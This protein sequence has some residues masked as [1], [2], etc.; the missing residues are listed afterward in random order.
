M[1]KYNYSEL[2]H[3]INSVLLHQGQELDGIRFG[4]KASIDERISESEALLKS[5]GYA[6]PDR[7]QATASRKPV[8]VV[9]SWE[10]LCREAELAVGT[11]TALE[12]IFTPEELAENTKAVR[13]MNQEYNMLHHLDKYDV[14]ISEKKGYDYEM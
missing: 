1:R 6:L 10:T 2:E 8:M 14:A 11:D 12:D 13:L 4:N 7:V 5:L 3:Q 9:P